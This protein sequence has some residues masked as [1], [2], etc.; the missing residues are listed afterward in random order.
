MTADRRAKA[1][2]RR[3]RGTRSSGSTPGYYDEARAHAGARARLRHL[4]RLPSLLQSLQRL[5]R[6]CST[7]STIRHRRSSTACRRTEYWKVVDQCY[8]CDMCYMTEVSVCAAASV[9]RRFS[10]P[11]AACE[12][13]CDFSEEGASLRD[14]AAESTDAVGS[15]P[16]FRS[17]PRSSTRRTGT[18]PAQAAGEARSAC[19]ATRRCRDYHSDTARKRLARARTTTRGHRRGRRRQPAAR[20]LLFT[21]CYGNRNAP[22]AG[23]GPGGGLRAQ[24]HRR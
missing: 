17:S 12:G 14:T 11:D 15:S 7:P 13:A 1:A 9:E 2:S 22:A 5:S 16:A 8:L 23:R 20:S 19:T 3:R 6:R 24:R 4:S 21:T 18:A 10:A